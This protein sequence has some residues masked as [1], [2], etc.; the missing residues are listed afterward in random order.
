MRYFRLHLEQHLWN[1][2]VL[3]KIDRRIGERLGCLRVAEVVGVTYSRTTKLRESLCDH[4]PSTGVAMH[5]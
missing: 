3:A 2:C 5:V 1:G 4:V